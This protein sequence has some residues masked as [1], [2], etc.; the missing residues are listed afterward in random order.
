MIVPDRSD[1]D[2]VERELVARHGCVFGGSIGTFDD[3]FERIASP[4]RR[5]PLATDAQQ[6]LR[7]GAPSARASLNGLSASARSAGFADALREAIREL[8]GAPA[9][10]RP[11]RGRPRAP[12]RGVPRRARHARRLG[13]R[14]APAPRPSSAS[15]RA[16][17]LARR[18]GFRLRLRGPHRRRVVAAGG[19]RRPHRGHGLA[20]VRAGPRGVRVAPANRRG[21]RDARRRAHRGAAAAYAEVAP[22][23]LAY[24]E[25]ALFEEPGAGERRRS[26][27][28]SRSSR[29]QACAGR[30]SSSATSCSRLVRGG[31]RAGR[32][33]RRLPVARPLARAARNRLPDA[34]HPVRLRRPRALRRDGLRPRAARAASLR[35]GGGSRAD[36]FAFL[37][38]PYSGLDPRPRRLRRGTPAR[39]GGRRARADRGGP[40]GASRRPASPARRRSGPGR[41]RST[42]CA[43][44]RSRCCAPRTGSSTRRWARA[45]GATSARYDACA[46]PARRARRLG[47]ARRGADRRRRRD[48][49]PRARAAAAASAAEPGKVA[50]L[51]LERARTRT[52]R[53]RLRARARG[54]QPS[55]ARRRRRRSSTTRRAS[56]SAAACSAPTRSAATATSS[57]P[58]ARA[59]RA[60]CT[61]CASPRPTRAARSEASPFWDEVRALFP[62]EE[63]ERATT[64][65]RLSELTWR[66]EEAP[67]DRERLRA[68]A[69]L[70]RDTPAEADGIARAN[71]WE[72]RLDRARRARAG[73]RAFATR[74][75]SRRSAR[76]RPSPSP[77]SS[78]SPTA[79]RRG[80]STG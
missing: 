35:V 62:R 11:P 76:E 55:A 25:R 61:S 24:L 9:R 17:R 69:S 29:A 65:R 32:D 71:G 58:R 68:L 48:R 14:A 6:Q 41:R 60:A 56:G 79:R 67:T 18:A 33:R 38:S 53:G 50:V 77:S 45:R 64:R 70:S 37:R 63:V 10:A 3:V 66:L 43:R 16:R 12:L 54:G 19:A 40:A 72:R 21:S 78:A 26:R 22:P 75:C 51:D 59:R 30:S 80:S 15:G 57:T 23:A 47:A 49:D 46:A 1:V 73:R 28:P 42:P 7:S 34:R 52:L 2:R 36:L 39:A 44:S 8:Q 5:R 27:A 74:S 4:A 13:P 20:A 31:N